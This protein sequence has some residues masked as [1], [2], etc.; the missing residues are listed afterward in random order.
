[1]VYFKKKHNKS[2]GLCNCKNKW[3]LY[4]ADHGR[5]FMNAELLD[6]LQLYIDGVR[7]IY[8][9]ALKAVVL[10]GSYARGDFTRE[11]DIDLMILL[12]LN[13]D[14]MKKKFGKLSD[15][16]YDFNMEHGTDISPVDISE[17]MY[18]K[19]RDDHSAPI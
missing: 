12:T 16:T 15:Y 10:Y 7:N 4:G 2:H 17:Y 19:W 13:S 18:E 3:S 9:S 11:S 1:M 14:D 6:I 5:L 8:G